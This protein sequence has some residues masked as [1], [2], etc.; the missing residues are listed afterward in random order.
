M[1]TAVR[2]VLER[3]REGE[4]GGRKMNDWLFSVW[5]S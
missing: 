4:G 1:Q 3:E 2:S 5:E